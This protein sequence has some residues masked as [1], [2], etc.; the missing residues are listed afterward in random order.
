M[1]TFLRHRVY[2][3]VVVVVADIQLLLLWVMGSHL[4][5]RSF[6]RNGYSLFLRH[7]DE[8]SYI[9]IFYLYLSNYFISAYVCNNTHMLC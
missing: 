1:W 2:K 9:F 8:V 4:L 3:V 5:V 6:S 7:V